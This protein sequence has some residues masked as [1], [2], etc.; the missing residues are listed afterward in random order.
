MKWFKHYSDS[1]SNLKLQAVIAEYG[2]EG[3]G[4]FWVCDELVAQQGEE[5]RIH[6]GKGWK[7]ALA[8]ITR[9]S[10]ERIDNM[11][12]FFAEVN[13][14]DQEALFKGDLYMPKLSEYGDE[15]SSRKKPT[16]T[17]SR[18]TP[19]VVVLEEIR[20]EENRRDKRRIEESSE[21]V[22]IAPT[23]KETASRFFGVVSEK[24]SEFESLV[25]SISTSA[26]ASPDIVSR[27]LIKFTSY[28]TEPNSTGTKQRWQKETTFEV[29]RRL[30]TWFGNVKQF[31]GSKE[32]IS[33]YI[34]A[35]V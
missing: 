7:K 20:I 3:Y 13:L 21:L 2:M 26:R 23:P 33:K 4:F 10:G 34:P 28:W 1:Y 6:A 9:I 22:A 8:Y 27:E 16:S 12:A 19:D 32:N 25:S 35:I 18:Q 17:N 14:L 5:S 11:L 29:K 30:I 15:Y 31:S 24:N